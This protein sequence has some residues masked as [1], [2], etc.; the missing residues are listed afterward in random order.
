MT[1]MFLMNLGFAGSGA[2]SV[3]R[4]ATLTSWNVADTVTTWGGTVTVTTWN[5]A[6]TVITRDVY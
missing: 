2:V 6:D 1:L 5:V 3:P 4:A